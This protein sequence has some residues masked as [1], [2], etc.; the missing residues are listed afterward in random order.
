MQQLSLELDGMG[1]SGCVANVR[2]ALG[3]VPGVQI[4]DVAIGSATLEYDP[5]LTSPSAIA[6]ALEEAG[7]PVRRSAPATAAGQ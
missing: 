5:A 4:K 6:T 2:R 3:T 7:Y 1:C